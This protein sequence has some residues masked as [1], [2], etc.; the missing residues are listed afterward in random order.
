MVRANQSQ[1]TAKDGVCQADE[2]DRASNQRVD[3]AAHKSP[4]KACTTSPQAVHHIHR[5]A[6]PR[7]QI[8][9][10]HH[11]RMLVRLGYN[12]E[13]SNVN[14]MNP[15]IS[16]PVSFYA[17]DRKQPYIVATSAPYRP[18]IEWAAWQPMCDGIRRKLYT[19]HQYMDMLS[20]LDSLLCDEV[21]T[22]E[23]GAFARGRNAAL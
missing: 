4:I 3:Y 22:T 12:Q 5:L 6:R 18:T 1:N 21:H 16:Y 11:E 13:Y 19:P 14:P 17:G 15:V 2:N 7:S 9:R 10:I 8:L 20:H 23:D